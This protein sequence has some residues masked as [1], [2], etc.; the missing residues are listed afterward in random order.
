MKKETIIQIPLEGDIYKD[1]ELLFKQSGFK[2]RS[3]YIR[4]LIK[5]EYYNK[6]KGEYN[7]K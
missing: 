5:Q 4:S 2:A 1:F 7:E 6:S 3:E